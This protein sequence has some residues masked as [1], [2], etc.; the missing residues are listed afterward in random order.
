MEAV[1]I[2]QDQQ[3]FLSGLYVLETIVD[4][5]EETT[6][7]VKFNFKEVSKDD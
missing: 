3:W 7:Y 2:P 5:Q 6:E 4:E 1:I